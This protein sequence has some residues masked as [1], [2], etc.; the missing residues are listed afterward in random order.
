MRENVKERLFD[1]FSHKLLSLMGLRTLSIKKKLLEE[2]VRMGKKED[3]KASTL[4]LTLENTLI[5]FL[6]PDGRSCYSH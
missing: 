3:Q 2:V 4:C 6:E 5:W 1:L